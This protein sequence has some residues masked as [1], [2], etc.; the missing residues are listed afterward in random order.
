MRQPAAAFVRQPKCPLP[1][2]FR[3]PAPNLRGKAGLGRRAPNPTLSTGCSPE[4]PKRF[5]GL[6]VARLQRR[7]PE[8][9]RK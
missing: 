3:S 8:R 2:S 6:R 4:I 1:L 9:S 5:R 7:D